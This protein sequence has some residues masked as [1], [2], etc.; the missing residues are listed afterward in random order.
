MADVEA[1]D[2]VEH[3]AVERWDERSRAADLT[4]LYDGSVTILM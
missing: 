3:Q 1:R 2:I 4:A